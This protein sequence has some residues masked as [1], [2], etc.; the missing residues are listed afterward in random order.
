MVPS[1]TNPQPPRILIIDD[2]IYTSEMYATTLRN[3]GYQVVVADNGLDGYQRM[4]S[5]PF[6]V[7]LLDIMLPQLQGDDVLKKWRET[8]P[9][10]T[11]PP[12]IILTN[13]EQDDASK[14]ALVESADGYVIKASITPR[15][16]RQIIAKATSF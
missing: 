3:A 10:G 11:K 15:K 1:K 5:E 12:V 6:D 13:Y 7:V 16:L 14:E 2:D 4:Q 9:K 8:R